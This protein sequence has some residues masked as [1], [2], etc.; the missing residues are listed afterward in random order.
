MYG[1][2]PVWLVSTGGDGQHP[3]PPHQV[4]P[5]GVVAAVSGSCH[6]RR[7]GGRG[8]GPCATARG[9]PASYTRPEYRSWLRDL[10]TCLLLMIL[11]N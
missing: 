11:L 5:A 9:T 3:P 10:G 8:R 1:A 2:G 4:I 6:W 7:P